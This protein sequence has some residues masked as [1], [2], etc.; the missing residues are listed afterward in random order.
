MLHCKRA[1]PQG[2]ILLVRDLQKKGV[3]GGQG[4]WHAFL[5]KKNAGQ[6][7]DPARLPWQTL[8]EFLGTLPKEETA[9]VR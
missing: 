8:A 9:K 1:S 3:E 4:S 7:K 6:M 5:E 2:L